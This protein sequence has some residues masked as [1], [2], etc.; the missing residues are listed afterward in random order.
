MIAELTDPFNPFNDAQPP[1]PQAPKATATGVISASGILI[2]DGSNVLM[3]RVPD[4]EQ[5][6]DSMTKN[7]KKVK[8]PEWT[9]FTGASMAVPFFV[10]RI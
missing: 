2:R 1:K 9:V 6:L 3:K 5:I 10:L 8:L 4:F 7:K